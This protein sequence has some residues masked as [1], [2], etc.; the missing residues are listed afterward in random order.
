MG[1][2]LL[3][4]L[5]AKE[6]SLGLELSDRSLKLCEVKKTKSGKS[7]LMQYAKA[8]LPEGF[9]EDGKITDW[10]GVENSLKELLKSK[11]FGTKTI[12]FAVPSQMV[13]VRNLKLPDIAQ[14]EL[15][16]LVQFEM[17]HNMRL[18]FEEPFFDFVKLP[19]TNELAAS[20][21]G[22]GDNLCEVMVVAAP[23]QL[24]RQYRSMFEGLGLQPASFEIKPFSVLRLIEGSKT[25]TVDVQLV[26]HVNELQSEITIISD[27]QIQITRYVE[28]AFQSI[29]QQQETTEN[30]WLQSYSS[31]ETTFHNAVQD[32]VG[33]MERLLNFYQYTLNSGGKKI[34]NVLLS[35][36]LPDMDELRTQMGQAMNQSVQLLEWPLIE[37]NLNSGG[38]W[39]L[40]AYA[41]ALGLALR[42]AER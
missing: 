42:G 24:L 20:D 23:A 31:P 26:V 8:D 15:K 1:E 7:R 11:R 16:K 33:E 3:H 34:N 14:A 37:S 2:S 5:F 17:S 32:L 28:V 35:G 13:M 40:S 38:E 9:I 10:L 30:E 25:E 12:H 41:V 22:R 39:S 19:K 4:K 21:E 27:G 29:V 6:H 36:D 18:A